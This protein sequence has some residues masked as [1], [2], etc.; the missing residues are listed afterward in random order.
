MLEDAASHGIDASALLEENIGSLGITV[1]EMLDELDGIQGRGLAG[2]GEAQVGGVVHTAIKT[3]FG[4]THVYEV[5]RSA[6]VPETEDQTVPVP[7]TPLTDPILVM[8]PGGPLYQ[9]KGSGWS[10][11]LHIAGGSFANVNTTANGQVPLMISGFG[12]AAINDSHI[13]MTGHLVSLVN[14]RFC[15]YGYCISIGFLHGNGVSFFEDHVVDGVE[16][17]ATPTI[18]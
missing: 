6:N 8:H 9:V 16:R 14:E 2:T 13:D 1:G 18:P 7:G 15:I 3:G 12:S 4:A 10:L 5:S 17:P 11:G